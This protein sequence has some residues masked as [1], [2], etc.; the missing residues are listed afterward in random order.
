MKQLQSLAIG[1]LGIALVL[2]ILIFLQQPTLDNLKAVLVSAAS[3][4]ASAVNGKRTL[5]LPLK[6]EASSDKRG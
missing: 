3:F 6:N 5:H 4:L 2:S 1:L